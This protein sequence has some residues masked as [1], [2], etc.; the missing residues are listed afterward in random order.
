MSEVGRVSSGT[1]HLDESMSAETDHASR[2]RAEFRYRERRFVKLQAQRAAIIARL[3]RW[4][5]WLL[6]PLNRSRFW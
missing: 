1:S 6:P 5:H 4:L 3:P 2:L